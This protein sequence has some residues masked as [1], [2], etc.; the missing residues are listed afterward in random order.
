[1]SPPL[2]Q[3]VFLMT[4]I[5]SVRSNAVRNARLK[6]GKAAQ[7][8]VHFVIKGSKPEFTWEPIEGAP[9]V[10]ESVA[11]NAMAEANI[12]AAMAVEKPAET[13]V[14]ERATKRKQAAERKSIK[15]AKTTKAVQKYLGKRVKVSDD[16]SGKRRQLINMITAKNGASLKAIC[17]RL[18]WQK[19]T[20]RGAISTA[21]D[22]GLIKHLIS[23]KSDRNGRMYKAEKVA[24]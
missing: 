24:A 20:V 1:M 10:A 5:F 8:G 13:K 15:K 23:F 9:T 14:A 7:Q 19:H 16:V 6:L 2:K 11:E 18:G 21:K 3:K 12:E 17:G 22:Q 4:K